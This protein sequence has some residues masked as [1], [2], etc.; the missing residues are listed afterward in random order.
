MSRLSKIVHLFIHR[1]SKI[2]HLLIDLLLCGIRSPR[3]TARLLNSL[4]SVMREGQLSRETLFAPQRQDCAGLPA[5]ANPILEIP[6]KDWDATEL[7]AASAIIEDPY[8]SSE[9]ICY[10]DSWIEPHKLG[11]I[12]PPYRPTYPF[13]GFVNENHARLASCPVRDGI[14]VDI[15]I[16]GWLRRE[17]A[18]KLYELAYYSP[19]DVLE[20]GT[21]QGLSAAIISTALADAGKGRKLVTIDLSQEF[22]SN[23]VVHLSKRRLQR[24]V[25]FLV[26]DATGM[27]EKLI[28][29]GRRFSFVFVD[30]S[31]EYGPVAAACRLMG[32]LIYPRGLCLF[33]DFNNARNNDLD[34]TDYRVSQ[35]VWNVLPLGQFE[36]YGIFGGTALYRAKNPDQSVPG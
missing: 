15:G 6:L 34:N 12:I 33:H 19:G 29:T 17:D 22:S 32:R 28:A 13:D 5:E 24:N 30:H 25:T 18:L 2:I 21:Y 35:A 9:L 26:G 23:A 4:V 10:R 1:L 7:R 36:F 31:H 11:S 27:C 14:L 3:E 8:E 16:P 20:L